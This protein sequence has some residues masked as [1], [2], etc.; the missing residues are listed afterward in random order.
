M[1][2]VCVRDD[3][4]VRA[5]CAGD[6]GLLAGAAAG[7]VI[8]IHSTILPST[9]REL[10]AVAAQRGVGVLDACVT[11]GAAGAEPGSSPTWSAARP[12]TSSERCRPAFETSRRRSST[13]ARSGAGPPP[14]S[15]T[16]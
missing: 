2:G 11:G 13:P 16:T 6:D 7:S 14:S 10:G 3:A 8:A 4:D 15:A 5:V 12:R 1:I 9:V